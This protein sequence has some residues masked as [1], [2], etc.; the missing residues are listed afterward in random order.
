MAIR[1]IV[2][3]T[4][5]RLAIIDTVVRLH[6]KVCAVGT[7][8]LCSQNIFHG[9]IALQIVEIKFLT[10]DIGRLSVQQQHLAALSN[11]FTQQFFRTFV[12]GVN[13]G[14]NQI[15][16]AAKTAAD[17]AIFD[18]AVL[19]KQGL[20]QEMIA[21]VMVCQHFNLLCKNQ[22]QSFCTEI[23]L[24][25]FTLVIQIGAANRMQ[26]RYVD[27]L[28]TI[29]DQITQMGKM[30]V[31]DTEIITHPG[32]DLRKMMGIIPLAL[33]MLR[34]RHQM[35]AHQIQAAH[36][37]QFCQPLQFHGADFP[38]TCSKALCQDLLFAILMGNAVDLMGRQCVGMETTQPVDSGNVHI[39]IKGHNTGAGADLIAKAGLFHIMTRQLYAVLLTPV[40]DLL[41]KAFQQKLLTGTPIAMTELTVAFLFHKQKTDV[42]SNILTI[43]L[44]KIF[45][46]HQAERR[47]PAI[48]LGFVCEETF[49]QFAELIAITLFVALMGA[50]QKF[51][52][53]YR[54]QDINSGNGNIQVDVEVLPCS[55]RLTHTHQFLCV[56]GIAGVGIRIKCADFIAQ[57]PVAIFLFLQKQTAAKTAGPAI[58]VISPRI[59][60][61]LPRFVSAGINRLHPLLRQIFCFQATTGVHKEATHAHFFHPANLA[62]QFLRLQLVIP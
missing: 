37:L 36:I 14:Q 56:H 18:K 12:D 50:V 24:I 39:L 19:G 16:I 60:T 40:I 44:L 10:L 7:I 25:N 32:R 8:R 54:I 57:V 29:G 43:M 28:L 33:A 49:N 9:H 4:Q 35:L 45:R 46:Q 52:D 61:D 53:N 48:K 38:T 17:L 62:A 31:E 21:Q 59:H 26:H 55:A 11:K 20:V 22:V 30:I 23:R 1:R 6:R 13:R 34:I 47:S 5:I 27:L 3:Y 58:F 51:P 15:L 41:T 42:I 2:L